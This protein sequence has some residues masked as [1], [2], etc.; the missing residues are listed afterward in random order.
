MILQ[1]VQ[2][3]ASHSIIPLAVLC[4]KDQHV[5]PHRTG[6]DHENIQASPH[7]LGQTGVRY[8]THHQRDPEVTPPHRHVRQLLIGVRGQNHVIDEDQ[9]LPPYP[10]L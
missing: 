2:N 10:C 3:K 6:V 5:P 9:H 4:G 1:V 7:A 8:R